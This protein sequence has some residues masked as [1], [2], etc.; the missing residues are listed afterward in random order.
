MGPRSLPATVFGPAERVSGGYVVYQNGRLKEVTNI[1]YTSLQPEELVYVK[2]HISEWGT[3]E[4]PLPLPGTDTWNA[5]DVRGDNLPQAEDILEPVAEEAPLQE[6]RPPDAR[7][8]I[9]DA[10]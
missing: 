3:P 2:G 6:E 9:I 4:G 1:N 8:R 7:D 5:E 10:I